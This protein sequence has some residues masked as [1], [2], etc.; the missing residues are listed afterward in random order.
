[1]AREILQAPSDEGRAS[2]QVANATCDHCARGFQ[3]GAGELLPVEPETIDWQ[4]VMLGQ[5][6]RWRAPPTWGE[7]DRTLYSDDLTGDAPPS[8]ATVRTTA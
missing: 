2:C 7:L 1:M 3:Q 4:S 5:S 6:A 8:A